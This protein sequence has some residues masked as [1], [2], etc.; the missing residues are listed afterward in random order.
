MRIASEEEE[1]DTEFVVFAYPL[2]YMLIAADQCTAW[3]NANE[4]ETRPDM[5]VD[6]ELVERPGSSLGG[7]RMLVTQAPCRAC[8][9]HLCTSLHRAARESLV[10]ETFGLGEGFFVARTRDHVDRHS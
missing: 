5:G 10:E 3:W 4:A 2:G 7:K 8:L 6:E 9:G 1:L